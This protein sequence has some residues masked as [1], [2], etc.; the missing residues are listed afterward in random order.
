MN[1]LHYFV[2]ISRDDRE[3][4]ERLISTMP[5]VPHTGK[6]KERVACA[7]R[8]GTFFLGTQLLPF[9]K[10]IGRHQTA[11]LA[12]RLSRGGL[13]HDVLGA[14]VA[15]AVTDFRIFGPGWH[16]SPLHQPQFP[17]A[18]PIQDHHRLYRLWGNVEGRGNRQVSAR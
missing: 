1:R 7:D 12:D 8:K 18:F 11:P 4:F 5:S 17:V 15:R 14:R 3:R 6:G 13:D 9:I 10:Q 2:R 16:K